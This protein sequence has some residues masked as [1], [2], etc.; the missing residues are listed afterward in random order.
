MH[1]ARSAS[2]GRR[3]LGS[4]GPHASAAQGGTPAN[5]ISPLFQ[6][7]NLLEKT[8]RL[9]TQM[10]ERYGSSKDPPSDPEEL[11]A[12]LLSGGLD[13]PAVRSTWD[14]TPGQLH[15]DLN[16]ALRA[17]QYLA[18]PRQPMGPPPPPGADNG[19]S[20]KR[21]LEEGFKDGFKGRDGVEGMFDSLGVDIN[22]D[23]LKVSDLLDEDLLPAKKKSS[24]SRS[25][26]NKRDPGKPMKCRCD[27]SG[28]LKRYCVCFADQ[29]M[30]AADCK[31]KECRN[32]ESTEERKIARDKAI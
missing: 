11:K 20:R 17:A 23:T 7:A 19:N 22:G 27:R 25:K 26:P 2:P 6:L 8:P 13:S 24:T 10:Q 3:A 18:S 12:A 21:K 16:H 30:C 29:R 28:C 32:D 5:D 9:P 1:R 4:R 14:D 31:C 15:R